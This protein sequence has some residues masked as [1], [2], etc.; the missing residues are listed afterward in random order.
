MSQYVVALPDGRQREDQCQRPVDTDPSP[1]AFSNLYSKQTS[2]IFQRFLISNV[3]INNY[4]ALA[5]M[6]QAH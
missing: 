1:N 5:S 3:N 4:V 6:C 2:Q